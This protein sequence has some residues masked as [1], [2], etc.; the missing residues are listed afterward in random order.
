MTVVKMQEFLCAECK[1]VIRADFTSREVAEEVAF[2]LGWRIFGG[3]WYC[4]N[5]YRTKLLEFRR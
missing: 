1:W 5:C 2:L 4:S 3:K